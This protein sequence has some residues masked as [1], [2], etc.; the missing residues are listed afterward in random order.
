MDGQKRAKTITLKAISGLENKGEVIPAM[1]PLH[2]RIIALV[3]TILIF[4]PYGKTASGNALLLSTLMSMLL[5]YC[6]L[7]WFR[8]N[9]WSWR[10]YALAVGFVVA[11]LAVFSGYEAGKEVIPLI[12]PLLWILASM[13][14]KLMKFSILLVVLLVAAAA[15]LNRDHPNLSNML[16]GACGLYLGCRGITFVK[17]AYRVST[18]HLAELDAAHSRLQK[19]HDELQEAT[20][21]SMRYAALSERT[22]L[23]RD[24]HDGIGHH[25]T[26]LIIQLQ[27]LEMML[28]DDP[29]AASD[30]V[31]SMLEVARK[32]MSEV[33]HAVRE[34]SEDESGTGLIALKGLASQVAA[35]SGIR[36]EFQVEDEERME[37]PP[38]TSVILFRVLQ[39]A[40]TN[41]MKHSEA[42]AVQVQLQMQSGNVVL[43]VSDNGGFA[44]SS[45]FTP[46]FGLKGMIERCESAGGRVFF[47][48]NV[49]RGF[50]VRAEIPLHKEA[51]IS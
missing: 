19:A 50:T 15:A 32:A 21:H 39:E 45:G 20:V 48:C 31:K 44:E 11:A 30:Q 13:P 5:V 33:R 22:R 9:D 35:H 7:I 38:Q 3:A 46:G 23:A 8:K 29:Q 41:T 18:Q 40:L 24:I 42:T 47:A 14:R 16:I 1:G 25:L 2:I 26:S 49:P 6:F 43:T 28:P 4:I 51:H 36:I 10:P 37:V 27:A 17:E 12:W 34:W